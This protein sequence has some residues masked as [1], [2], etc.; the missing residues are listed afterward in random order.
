MTTFWFE[1]IAETEI[2]PHEYNTAS[3]Q[4][5]MGRFRSW[6]LGGGPARCRSLTVSQMRARLLMLR[7]PM[8]ALRRLEVPTLITYGHKIKDLGHVPNAI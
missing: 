4:R 5:L 8:S 1:L 6:R 7:L 3:S 2:A